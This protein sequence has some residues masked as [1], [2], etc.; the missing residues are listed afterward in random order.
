MERVLSIF[1]DES[2]DMGMASAHSPYYIV[3]LVFHDQSQP[4]NEQADRLKSSLTTEGF[5]PDEAIHTGPLIRREQQYREHT[6]R[7]RRRILSHL[8]RFARHC[9]ITAKTFAIDKRVYGGGR[10]LAE[11]LAREMGSFVSENL[12]MFQSFEHVIVYYDHGQT[13]VFNTLRTIF[14]TAL[15]GAEFRTVDPK[16][17]RLFQV[18]DLVC[19]LELLSQKLEAGTMSNSERSFF[20]NAKALRRNHLRLLHKLKR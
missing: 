19:T 13:E 5:S 7:D 3:A 6:P 15:F 8:E 14:G 20:G 17:Y 12:S 10:D 2:G 1:C 4:I 11:R 9:P 18:A 16:D